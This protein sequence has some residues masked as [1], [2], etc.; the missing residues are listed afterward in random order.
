MVKIHCRYDKLVDIADLVPHA[1]NHNNH[2]KKQVEALAD[3]L[4]YQGWRRS[5]V[6]SNRSNTVTVGNGR[7]MAA[8]FNHER[9]PNEGWNKVP[10]N[11]QDY[12]SD[13]MEYA[14]VQ[15]DNAIALW[16]KLDIQAI[17]LD[18]KDFPKLKLETLGIEK[19]QT[20][21]GFARDTGGTAADLKKEP[22]AKS[23]DLWIL[24]SHR[25]FCG[26]STS[27][28]DFKMLLDGAQAD[29]VFTSPP[30][31][32]GISYNGYDDKKTN[33]EYM[34]M[35][36]AVIKNCFNAMRAG[37]LIGWNVGVS[38]KSKP[39]HHAI[40]LEDAGFKLFRHIVWKKTGAQ[41]PLW[42]NAKKNP[43]A[44]N[45]MPNYN[46]EMVY[47]MVKGELEHGAA[48]E[49]PED[50]SMDVW[51][52]SQFAAGGNNHPA[53]FPV[54]LAEMAIKVMTAPGEIA[55]E[56]FGGSGSTIIACE[57]ANRRCFAMEID[58]HYVDVAV[59]RWEKFT[60]KR[61]QLV[62]GK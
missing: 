18:L 13:E 49:M 39:Y 58:P 38:P 45:Y 53:A 62:G 48:T 15:A 17:K 35:M 23:G 16:A 3:I 11:F 22:I 51:D 42:Q 47:M 2:P 4:K 37:R 24:G 60:G 21:D 55:L 10:V 56:P 20:V 1:K 27:P 59:A 28:A 30:Y 25:I 7:V 41:I 6:Q 29:A 19:L 14:D 61:A 43:V 32:V 40:R 36:T 9:F 57:K 8:A 5:V 46:H 54:H 50:L 26:D 31:N 44:R 12:D 33:D 52:V 34:A